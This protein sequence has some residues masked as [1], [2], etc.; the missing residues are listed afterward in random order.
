[1]TAAIA[2]ISN[3]LL[4][5]RDCN[6]EVKQEHNDADDIPTGDKG[7]AVAVFTANAA[8]VD[9]RKRPIRNMDERMY[10]SSGVVRSCLDF[11]LPLRP[12]RRLPRVSKAAPRPEN[13]DGLR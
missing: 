10:V 3:R 2:G 12:S 5:Q 11:R 8:A 1:M 9:T 6:T 13:L 7:V 4:R